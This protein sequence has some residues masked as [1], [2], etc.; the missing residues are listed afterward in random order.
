MH[1]WDA[2]AWAFWRD[3]RH[4]PGSAVAWVLA[5]QG[6]VSMRVSP[7]TLPVGW[8]FLARPVFFFSR[9]YG[10]AHGFLGDAFWTPGTCGRPAHAQPLWRAAPVS[11]APV[12]PDLGTYPESARSYAYLFGTRFPPTERAPLKCDSRPAA[13]LQ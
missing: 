7:T 11:R 1:A 13:A 2:R 6:R 5:T 10:F 8:P 3:T 12:L 4:V 9:R